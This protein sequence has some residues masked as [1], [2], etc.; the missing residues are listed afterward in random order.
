MKLT[1]SFTMDNAA[2][3]GDNWPI[4]ASRI[5]H[6]LARKV[7]HGSAFD[8]AVLHDINGNKVGDCGIEGEPT[9]TTCKCSSPSCEECFGDGC[10]NRADGEVRVPTYGGTAHFTAMCDSCADGTIDRNMDAEKI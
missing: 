8:G 5:L 4:E 1:L 6:D 9:E 3:D 10:Q 2:F 7:S